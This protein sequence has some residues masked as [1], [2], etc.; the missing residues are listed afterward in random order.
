[1]PAF[2]YEYVRV[3]AVSTVREEVGLEGISHSAGFLPSIARWLLQAFFFCAGW[4]DIHWILPL[5][6]VD[7]SERV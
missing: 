2:V 4:R 7:G 5:P 3:R 6:E 1:M